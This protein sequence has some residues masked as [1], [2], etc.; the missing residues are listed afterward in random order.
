M[1]FLSV[2]IRKNDIDE[3]PALLRIN[4]IFEYNEVI[5]T[6]VTV[7]SGHIRSY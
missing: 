2:K 1:E 5:M 3:L 6:Y 4:L 7:L